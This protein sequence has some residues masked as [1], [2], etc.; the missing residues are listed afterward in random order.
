MHVDDEV[1]HAAQA[2]HDLSAAAVPPSALVDLHRLIDGL[3][4][5]RRCACVR[6]LEHRP[7]VRGAAVDIEADGEQQPHDRN[8][9]TPH[10][11]VHHGVA[12][13]VEQVQMRWV[14]MQPAHRCL[15]VVLVDSCVQRVGIATR[16]VDSCVQ[17]VGL[18]A[19]HDRTKRLA[20]TAL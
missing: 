6:L 10:G 15:R 5:L 18:A 17:R 3:E 19:R 11:H 13:A 9:A 14:S 12:L 8:V 20:K 16:L 1:G 2:L 4:D 7:V